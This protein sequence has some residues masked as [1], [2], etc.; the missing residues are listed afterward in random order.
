[1]EE[2][3]KRLPTKGLTSVD[4]N[5]SS[6]INLRIWEVTHELEELFTNLVEDAWDISGRLLTEIAV[7][8][9][10]T[11]YR[12]EMDSYFGLYNLP[13]DIVEGYFHG[14]SEINSKNSVILESIP[15]VIEQVKN[16]SQEFPVEY[17]SRYIDGCVDQLEQIH[18]V[19]KE[20]HTKL[21]NGPMGVVRIY[22]SSPDGF[23]HNPLPP[24]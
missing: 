5:F 24:L 11:Q 8:I 19:T 17:S 22:D 4:Y 23:L 3:A 16:I 12:K 2:I 15:D 18:T 7:T 14:F 9:D 21:L 10:V 13:V 1:M 6:E 20:F